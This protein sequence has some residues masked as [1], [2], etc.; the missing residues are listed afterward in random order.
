MKQ[1]V[2][3]IKQTQTKRQKIVFEFLEPQQFLEEQERLLLAQ[4]D[5]LDEEIVRIQNEN[6]SK[7]S[8][9]IFHLSELISE[10]EG[11]CQKPA[12]EFLQSSTAK[13]VGKVTFWI[14][15]SLINFILKVSP[16]HRKL[17]NSPFSGKD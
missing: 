7:I 3:S 6:V 16:L 11:K 14:Q 17:W 10:L 5:K 1:V 4:L 15:I 9:E 12:S 2:P 13:C 8:E